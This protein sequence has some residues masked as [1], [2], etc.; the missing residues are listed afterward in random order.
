M[1]QNM[2]KWVY[3]DMNQNYYLPEKSFDEYI[4]LAEDAHVGK[5][6]YRR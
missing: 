3:S 4:K 6:K 2:P 1:N 5:K